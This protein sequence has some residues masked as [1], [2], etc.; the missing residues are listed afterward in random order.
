MKLIDLITVT[1]ER[2]IDIYSIDHYF[3]LRCSTTTFKIFH[4]YLSNMEVENI[5]PT[6]G[7]TLGVRLTHTYENIKAFV[8]AY[9]KVGETNHGKET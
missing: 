4:P 1:E 2:D 8:H 3:L 9:F 6:A 7:G 5:Y